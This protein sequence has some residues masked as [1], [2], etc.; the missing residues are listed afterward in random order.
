MVSTRWGTLMAICV[1]CAAGCQSPPPRAS[2]A[3]ERRPPARGSVRAFD[4]ALA[5]FVALQGRATTQHQWDA[6]LR[7]VQDF[8]QMAHANDP[9]SPLFLTVLADLELATTSPDLAR[10]EA[11]YAQA[12]Q[13]ARNW[14]AGYLGQARCARLRGDAML[15]REALSRCDAALRYLDEGGGELDDVR[16]VGTLERTPRERRALMQDL[17]ARRDLWEADRPVTQGPQVERAMRRIKSDIEL[18]RLLL[19]SPDPKPSEFDAVLAWDPEYGEVILRK[20]TAAY[21]ERDYRTARDLLLP[22]VGD[23]THRMAAR[24]DARFLCGASLTAMYLESSQPR[25]AQAGAA[26]LDGL[27]HTHPWRRDALVMA[28]TLRAGAALKTKDP[29]VA[30]RALQDV[31]RLEAMLRT[32]VEGFAAEAGDQ[33]FV[34]EARQQL[35]QVR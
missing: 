21:N 23:P 11:W 5:R 25:D 28:I 10:A 19:Q 24:P 32:P 1:A 16:P 31:D 6:G 18:E 4:E 15:A 9:H 27:V 7:E 35:E 20:A 29:S 30:K 22:I 34:Q 2:D 3:G 8:V 13:N 17:L 26:L 14:P 33:A 12:L